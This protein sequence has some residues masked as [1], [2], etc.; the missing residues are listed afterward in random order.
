MA[1]FVFP[2]FFFFSSLVFAQEQSVIA[3]TDL[4]NGGNT[5]STDAI[6]AADYVRLHI[7]TN[8]PKY[9]VLDKI[10][11]SQILAA[12]NTTS[13][14][15]CTTMACFTDLGSLLSANY[16][17][18]GKLSRSKSLIKLDLELIDVTASKI[19]NRIQKNTTASKIDFY[20][21]FLPK[22]VTEL[23]AV[24]INPRIP[25]ASNPKSDSGLPRSAAKDTT[26]HSTAPIVLTSI[27]SA[28]ALVGIGGLILWNSRNGKTGF[29]SPPED[30]N[31]PLDG[32]P[33]RTRT[34]NLLP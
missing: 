8:Y 32:S 28:A 19:I 33:V 20:N 2:L 5:S 18:G 12:Q 24:P 11:M 16:L 6:S 25:V 22:A 34:T 4:A 3:V 13:F 23:L 29:N 30:G 26:R 9:I 21:N 15:V 17:V 7:S 1:R 10:I 27:G 14:P 31:V